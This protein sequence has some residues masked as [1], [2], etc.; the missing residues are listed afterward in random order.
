MFNDNRFKIVNFNH[1]MDG[2]I[3]FDF[4]PVVNVKTRV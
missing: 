3:K 4:K 2:E 1:E